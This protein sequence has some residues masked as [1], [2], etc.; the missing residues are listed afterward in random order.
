VFLALRL[1]IA[2]VG[3]RNRKRRNERVGEGAVLVVE[4]VRGK[5]GGVS[6]LRSGANKKL[7]AGR[8]YCRIGD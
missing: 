4:E 2:R 5:D 7:H 8:W 3:S 1:E 6:L